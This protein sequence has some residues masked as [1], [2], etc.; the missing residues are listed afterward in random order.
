MPTFVTYSYPRNIGLIYYQMGGLA[1]RFPEKKIH[2]FKSPRHQ[3]TK[4]Q[5][6]E[7]YQLSAFS[8]GAYSFLLSTLHSV[9]IIVHSA[10]VAG[11]PDRD[12][13]AG[14]HRNYR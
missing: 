13:Q 7:N 3:V 4:S 2:D 11:F 9:L 6:G 8:P 1:R 10:S 5:V 12:A 14:A